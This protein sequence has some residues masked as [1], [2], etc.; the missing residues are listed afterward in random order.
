MLILVIVI[1]LIL[2]IFIILK[3]EKNNEVQ[4]VKSD[5]DGVEYL[6]RKKPDSLQ[7]A[8]LLGQINLN[9][10][11]FVDYVYNKRNDEGYVEN[12]AYIERLHDRIQG[13]V[14]SES[15]ENSSYTSFS[16]NK[17]EA[18]IFCL[19]SKY[20]GSFHD[21]NLLLYVV[22]HEITHI[23]TI[24]QGHEI[25]FKNMFAAIAKYA[26]EMGLYKK[27]DFAANPVE[28]CGITINESII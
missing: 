6:V 22:L 12:K 28:Y 26:V 20:D 10:K 5:V 7:A 1:L 11:K 25:E 16:I 27:I 2:A 24:Q 8:N 3:L 4:Y 23:C 18:L 17:G 19:R 14:I 15:D 9:I 21:M 13:V